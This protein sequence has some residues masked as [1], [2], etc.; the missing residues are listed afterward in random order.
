MSVFSGKCDVYD[1]L[2]MIGNCTDEKLANA[3]FY[4]RTQDGRRHKIDITSFYDLIP[5]FPYL[6]CV[7]AHSEGSDYVELSSESFV[8]RE[9]WEIMEWKLRDIKNAYRKLKRNKQ[10]ITVEKLYEQ[11]AF[12]YRKDDILYKIAERF[13][14]NKSNTDLSGIHNVFHEYYR[15]ELADVMIANGYS[16]FEAL[17]WCFNSSLLDEETLQ[18]YDSVKNKFKEK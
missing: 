18:R 15:T 2:I 6:V 10:E 5:Y 17:T 9:E 16:E 1:T 12:F 7:H 8:D 3:R 13:L 14:E 11:A 4:I